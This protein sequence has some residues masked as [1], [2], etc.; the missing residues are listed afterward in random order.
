MAVLLLGFGFSMS[1][2]L[3]VFFW[4]CVQESGRI[5]VEGTLCDDYFKVR[6]LLYE[7]YAIV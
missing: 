3:Y 2:L 7:Q 6:E 5:Q 1:V 4:F